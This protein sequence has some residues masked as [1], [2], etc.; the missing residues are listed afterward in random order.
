MVT[1]ASNDIKILR[2]L[3]RQYAG[4]ANKPVQEERRRLWSAHLSLKKTKPLVMVSYGI[5][6]MWCREVFGDSAMKCADPFY[7]EHERT[8]RMKIFH[9]SIGDDYILEPWITQAASVKGT[10]RNLWGFNEDHSAVPMEGGSWKY[11]PP[12]KDWADLSKLTYTPHE[13]DEAQTRRN[14]ERLHEAVGDILPIDVTR[15]PA[16][17][18]FMGD[19]STSLAGLRG[20]EQL[21]IDMYESPAELHRLLAFMRDGILKNNREAEDAGHYSLTTQ[22]NQAMPY[23][24]VLERPRPNSGP[25]K[26]KDLWG[27]CAA[28]EFTLISPAFH[29]E[30]LI[31]YQAPIYEHFGL[32]HYGCCENLTRKIDILRQFKTLRSIAVTPTADVRQCAD[33]IGRNYVISWRPNPTDMVCAGWDETRIRRI[34]Q[35]GLQASRN[36]FTHVHL[37]DIE[38]VQGDPTRLARWTGIVRDIA[39]KF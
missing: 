21:M 30:F 37:K 25:R 11:E 35:D 2:E 4:L 16:C 1:N 29:D 20:L 12:L 27:F 14:V 36:G 17:S 13:V 32:V 38:T 15:A 3:A 6:N 31:R 33:Q 5:W 7:R 19:I 8:L 26:R 23:S 9:D 24:D 39:D 28:Q 22:E 10:W 34:I 18:H